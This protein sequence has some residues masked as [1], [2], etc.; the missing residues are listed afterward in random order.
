MSDLNW[1]IKAKW[2]WEE[3]KKSLLLSKEMKLKG[4]CQKTS[5]GWVLIKSS[6]LWVW[7]DGS[8]SVKKKKPEDSSIKTISFPEGYD[9][10][11]F[12]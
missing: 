3:M 11:N 1:I 2:K 10:H 7:L 9:G 5:K 6:R 8:F 4:Y 12:T